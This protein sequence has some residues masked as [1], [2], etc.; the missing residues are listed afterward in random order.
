[1]TVSTNSVSLDDLI[2][3]ALLIL[4]VVWIIV[5]IKRIVRGP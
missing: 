4:I 5:G 2:A 1:M 3:V